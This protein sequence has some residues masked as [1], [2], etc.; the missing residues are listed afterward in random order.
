MFSLGLRRP[1]EKQ[2]LLQGIRKELNEQKNPFQHM[3][4]LGL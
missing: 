4:N 2:E 3:L 1:Q